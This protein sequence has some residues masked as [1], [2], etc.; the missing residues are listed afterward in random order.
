M[1][2][3]KKRS[4]MGRTPQVLPRKIWIKF[5]I[6][7]LHSKPMNFILVQYTFHFKKNSN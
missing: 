4:V 7:I 6:R 2:T 5:G 3:L 1:R